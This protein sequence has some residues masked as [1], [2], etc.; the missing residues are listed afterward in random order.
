MRQDVENKFKFMFRS[1]TVEQLGILRSALPSVKGVS[2][3]DGA[4]EE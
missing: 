1:M 4:G 3:N 2:C